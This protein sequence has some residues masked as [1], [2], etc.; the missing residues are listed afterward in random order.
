MVVID[1]L[2]MVEGT[3]EAENGVRHLIAKWTASPD[4][5]AQQP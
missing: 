5:A 4:A 2:L 1:A 3:L